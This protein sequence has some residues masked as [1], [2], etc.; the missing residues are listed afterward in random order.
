MRPAARRRL[1]VLAANTLIVPAHL[2]AIVRSRRSR[3]A[4]HEGDDE[5]E[6]P[7]HGSGEEG[8]R[9][10]GFDRRVVLVR[11]E[12]GHEIPA[13]ECADEIPGDAT[14]DD[15]EDACEHV[16]VTRRDSTSSAVTLARALEPGCGRPPRPRRRAPCRAGAFAV[17]ERVSVCGTAA[18]SARRRLVRRRRS[19]RR[20]RCCHFGYYHTGHVKQQ[21]RLLSIK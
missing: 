21:D 18:C 10:R 1:K 19:L 2:A 7:H 8:S 13:A 14:A 16:S 17:K 9:H 15:E 4:A 6:Q 5:R 3:P 20:G 12:H 11:R